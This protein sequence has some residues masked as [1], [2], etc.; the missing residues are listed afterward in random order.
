MTMKKRVVNVEPI[1]DGVF[2]SQYVD[3]NDE[4]VL[5]KATPVTGIVEAFNSLIVHSFDDDAPVVILNEIH[6]ATVD[7]VD[8]VDNVLTTTEA[9]SGYHCLIKEDTVE[10][11]VE[12]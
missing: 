5:V 11:D 4:T 7:K 6:N 10:S 2:V 9:V 8:K 3:I 12:P 1:G